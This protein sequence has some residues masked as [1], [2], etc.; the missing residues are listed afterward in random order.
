[1]LHNGTVSLKIGEIHL[2]GGVAGY[3]RSRRNK[4][5]LIVRCIEILHFSRP[6]RR[7][8]ILLGSN[9]AKQCSFLHCLHSMQLKH[10]PNYAMLRFTLNNTVCFCACFPFLLMCYFLPPF[11]CPQ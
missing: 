4:K 10:F 2:V 7:G 6:V 3:K 8:S 11:I 5:A 9:T 1:M